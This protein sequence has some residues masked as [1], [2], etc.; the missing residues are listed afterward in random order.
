MPP[1][2]P[3]FRSLSRN[4]RRNRII[5]AAKRVM[6]EKGLDEASMDDVAACAGTTKPTVYAHFKSKDE[7][8]GAVVDFVREAFLGKLK[9]PDAYGDEPVEAIALFCARFVELACWRDAVG[10][11]RVTLAAAARS[12][13]IARAVYD[14]LFAGTCRSL[15]AYLRAS[16]LTRNPELDAELVLSA[17]T[18]GPVI[19]HLYGVIEPSAE[20]PSDETVGTRIDMK[21]IRDAVRL[22]ASNWKV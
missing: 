17:A 20:L 7:L 4:E 13:A 6:L 5:W 12:P 11:Q 10:Y 1:K 2:E 18:G 14:T 16:K 21:R 8:F 22:V 3:P 19:R 15:A 9:R